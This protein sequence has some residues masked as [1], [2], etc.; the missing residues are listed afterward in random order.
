MSNANTKVL[1]DNKNF[2]KENQDLKNQILALK[3]KINDLNK[4]N[5]S[6]TQ[7]NNALKKKNLELSNEKK[8]KFSK[9]VHENHSTIYFKCNKVGHKAFECN[10]KRIG[11]TFVKQIWVPKGTTCTNP[12]GPKIAWVPK[13]K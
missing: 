9:V 5:D 2:T 4:V 6:L 8:N 11:H 10:I 13:F 3:N 12:K 7:E 1:K